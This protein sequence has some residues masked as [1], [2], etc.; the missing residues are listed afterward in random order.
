MG[1]GF[2]V[3]NANEAKLVELNNG[4][5]LM[6]IRQ[7]GNRIFAWSSNRGSTWYKASHMYDVKDS[8]ANADIIRYTSVIDGFNKNR[9]LHT[10]TYATTRRTNL[11]L[12][13]SYD[14]GETWPYKRQIES[15]ASAYS[16]VTTNNDGEIFVAYEKGGKTDYDILVARLTLEW[17]TF[18]ADHYE[19][20]QLLN[21]CLTNNKEDSQCPEGSYKYPLRNFQV[22]SESYGLY[23]VEM[24]YTFVEAMDDF[25]VDLSLEGLSIGQ[26]N[27][28]NSKKPTITF[29]GENHHEN[30]RRFTFNKV[31]LK[32]SSTNLMKLDLSMTG[33]QLTIVKSKTT[34]NVTISGNKVIILE[35]TGESKEITLGEDST[36]IL[37]ENVA[38]LRLLTL[39]ENIVAHETRSQTKTQT[40]SFNYIMSVSIGFFIVGIVSAILSI[41]FFF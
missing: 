2:A 28:L 19:K 17:L 40:F 11:S 32:T 29:V 8:D 30:E 23:P 15:L 13:V 34:K 1:E 37:D 24:R 38:T 41:R 7:N 9:L 22:Y 26:Y 16:S 6:S 33:S 39:N 21:W 20:P 27:N 3:S 35:K 31:N 12:L 25:K 4:S 10:V 18:G 5:V 14:E 36:A